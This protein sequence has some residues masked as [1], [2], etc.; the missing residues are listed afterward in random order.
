MVFRSSYKTCVLFIGNGII[1]FPEFVDL[2]SRRPMGHLGSEEE[3]RGALSDAFDHEN[4]GF[5][6]V[7]EFRNAMKSM[8]E[9][10]S[11]EQLDEMLKD[12]EGDG[13]GMVRYEGDYPLPASPHPYLSKYS[14]LLISRDSPNS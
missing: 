4:D 8:G 14:T 13:D 12:F 10:L 2:M 1:E 11:D 6:N 7:S 9:K 5:L 3:L